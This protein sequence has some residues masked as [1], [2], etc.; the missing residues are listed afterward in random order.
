[1]TTLRYDEAGL[2]PAIAQD[3]LTGQVRMFAWMNAEALR[4]T[5]ETGRATFFSRSRQRLWTKGETSGN[6][7]AVSSVH[8]D[9]DEDVLL[10]MVDPAGPSCHTGQPTC[11]FK[12]VTGV[13]ERTTE[14][15]AAAAFLQVLEDDLERRK[16][17]PASQSYTRQLLEAGSEKIA[18]KLREE[19]AELGEAIAN[20][21]DERVSGEAGDLLYHLMVGLRLR[22]ISLRS[23]IE[24]LAR[25]SGVSGLQEKASRTSPSKP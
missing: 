5:L 11:F 2:I 20:E 16:A 19:A 13:G 8:A 23:V 9:C 25:R 7:L 17:S 6:T 22:G 3:R 1:M 12:R 4:V 21:S 18:E 10:L 15:T 14:A 24:V